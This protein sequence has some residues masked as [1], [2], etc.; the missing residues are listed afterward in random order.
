[1]RLDDPLVDGGI[2]SGH[3]LDA[4][5]RHRLA[6]DARPVQGEDARQAVDHLLEVVE[7]DPGDAVVD[8]LADRAAIERRDRSAAGH[9]FGQ[10]EAERLARL[11]RIEQGAGAAEQPDLG[12]E[13]GLAEID[14]LLPIDERRDVLVIVRLFGRREYQPH[15]QPRARR[16][17][18]A[19]RPLPSVNRPRNSR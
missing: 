3:A 10:D 2:F 14:D 18:P 11:N 15:A 17:S 5:P 9:R 12:I 7:H 4:E 8:D 16:R 13:V 6:P 1:M 19:A